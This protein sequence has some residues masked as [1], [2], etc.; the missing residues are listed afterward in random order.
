MTPI[1]AA[2]HN[3]NSRTEDR[4]VMMSGNLQ[5]KKLKAMTGEGI[6]T[7]QNMLMIRVVQTEA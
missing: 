6:L 4:W 2:R 3:R 7:Q 1:L 5:P